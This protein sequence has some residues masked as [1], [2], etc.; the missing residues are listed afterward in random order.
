MGDIQYV[1][2]KD[3]GDDASQVRDLMEKYSE[4]FDRDFVG[5]TLIVHTKLHNVGGRVKYSFHARIDHPQMLAKA[6]ASDWDLRRTVHK[7]MKALEN[8]VEHKFKTHVQKQERFHPK[9][10]KR[11]TDTRVRLKQ[12]RR[13]RT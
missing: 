7:M 3:L 11:G 8:E 9:R 1:G 13:T 2:L 6:D 12:K 5:H 10:A 4:K